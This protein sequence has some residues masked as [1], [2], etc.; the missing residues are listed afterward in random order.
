MKSS[1]HHLLVTSASHLVVYVSVR[2]VCCFA[3]I[4]QGFGVNV[5]MFEMLLSQ[6]S[7][8]SP[9]AIRLSRNSTCGAATAIADGAIAIVFL[10]MATETAAVELSSPYAPAKIEVS[11]PVHT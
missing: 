8:Q 7:C 4:L 2:T 10:R 5:A 3:P 11:E 1:Q 9:S 6:S